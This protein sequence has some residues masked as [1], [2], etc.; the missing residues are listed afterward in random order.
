M[1]VSIDSARCQG[2]ARCIAFASE[3]FAIDEEGY[4]HVREGFETV[5]PD[6][7]EGVRKACANCPEDAIL[8]SDE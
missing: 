5:N 3:V 4:S 1:K 8:L 2:H 6:L 7:Q